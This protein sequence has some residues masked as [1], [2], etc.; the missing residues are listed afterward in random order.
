MPLAL[1]R[2]QTPRPF[3]IR[4]SQLI[5]LKLN[6]SHMHKIHNVKGEGMQRMIQKTNSKS[7]MLKFFLVRVDLVS[8]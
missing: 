6:F 3:S 2:T 8:P 4:S 1:T 7:F 5:P